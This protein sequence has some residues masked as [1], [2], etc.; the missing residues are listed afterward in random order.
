VAWSSNPNERLNRERS[1]AA[2]VSSGSFPDQ[3]SAIRLIGDV[4]ADQHDEWA[5]GRRYLRLDLLQRSPLMT[6]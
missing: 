2:L 4:L 3:S 5:E 1:A 6:N